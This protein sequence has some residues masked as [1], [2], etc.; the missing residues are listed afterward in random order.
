VSRRRLFRLSVDSPL[1][2]SM[3]RVF[4]SK[5]DADGAVRSM[6]TAALLTWLDVVVDMN[7]AGSITVRLEVAP[8]LGPE[9]VY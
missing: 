3:E 5:Y 9:E 7:G 1:L 4:T 2:G 6:L 8:A